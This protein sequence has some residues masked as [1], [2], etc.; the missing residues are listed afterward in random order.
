MRLKRIGHGHIS[1]IYRF[2]NAVDVG[3]LEA[4]IVHGDPVVLFTRTWKCG[5]GNIFKI[6]G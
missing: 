2:V 4:R 5:H 3:H 6:G 1:T